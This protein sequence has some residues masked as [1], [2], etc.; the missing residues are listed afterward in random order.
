MPALGVLA[1]VVLFWVGPFASAA[2]VMWNDWSAGRRT[3]WILL[4]PVF[5]V[6]LFAL[7]FLPFAVE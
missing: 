1:Y 7:V 6:A 4:V 2:A 5:I 3:V